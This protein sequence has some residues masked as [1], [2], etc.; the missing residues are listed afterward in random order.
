MFEMRPPQRTW[1]RLFS[2]AFAIWVSA[3]ISA[4]IAAVGTS[5]SRAFSRLMW[6]GLVK[7][8]F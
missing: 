5:H 7:M 4:P 2:K 1:P 8:S 3:G 6:N